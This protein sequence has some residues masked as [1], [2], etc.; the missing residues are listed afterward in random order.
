MGYNRGMKVKTSITL[1]DELLQDIDR[2]SKD[3]KNRS[4]FIEMAVR[5][6]M[7]QINRNLQ[8]ANDVETINNNAER[9][10]AEAEDV[11]SYQVAL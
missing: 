11:L 9:P 7:R 8:N 10:N 2:F 3:Y 5:A 4:V 6:Y 1:S